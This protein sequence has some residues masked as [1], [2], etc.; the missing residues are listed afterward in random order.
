MTKKT[1][2]SEA[3]RGR[4]SLGLGSTMLGIRFHDA[5]LKRIERAAKKAKVTPAEIV[6]RLADEH[7]S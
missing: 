7:L 2:D 5:L 3:A 4:P 1:K 6:R